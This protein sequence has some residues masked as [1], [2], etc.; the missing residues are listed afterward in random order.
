MKRIAFY[1]ERGGKD[2]ALFNILFASWLAYCK[3]ERVILQDFNDGGH[4][5]Y[6]LRERELAG[7]R[8]NPILE[9][10]RFPTPYTINT[11]IIGDGIKGHQEFVFYDM[12]TE[13]TTGEGYYIMNFFPFLTRSCAF[14]KLVQT[15]RVD[16]VVIPVTPD[17]STY[18]QGMYVNSIINSP[19][20]LNTSGKTHQDSLMLWYK[21]KDYKKTHY[22]E[23]ESMF[24]RLG[25]P[26][27]SQRICEFQAHGMDLTGHGPIVSTLI[28]PSDTN[29]RRAPGLEEAFLEIKRRA[30]GIRP[31]SSPL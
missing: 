15:G 3:G 8:Q 14:A 27:C 2:M 29:R 1:R 19:N 11:N 24:A 10:A 31:G 30:D 21:D 18:A 22:S 25:I 12:T 5:V 16:L 13:A 26:V 28:Y 7:I 20:F 9:I 4:P 17:E 6:D 23:A